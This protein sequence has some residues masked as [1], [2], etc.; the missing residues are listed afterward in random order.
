MKNSEI[1]V[2][3]TDDDILIGMVE[4]SSEGIIVYSG[5]VGRPHIVRLENLVSMKLA[6]E[7]PDV[8]LE[9]SAD[10]IKVG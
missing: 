2:I 1:F 3:E 10:Y 6:E 8:V 5:F 4:L 7:H 9:T